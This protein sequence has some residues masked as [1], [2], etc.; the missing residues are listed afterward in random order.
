M[1][2]SA[3]AVI[4]VLYLPRDDRLR[5]IVRTALDFVEE[6]YRDELLSGLKFISF[7]LDS[8]FEVEN[9]KF[10]ASRES[11]WD[12]VNPVRGKLE[13]KPPFFFIS[14]YHP[15][16][17]YVWIPVSKHRR[18]S[19]I[20]T[21][22]A[23]ELA[24]HV[25]YLLPSEDVEG[26]FWA[27]INDLELY[28]LAWRYKASR[29]LATEIHIAIDEMIAIY[30]VHNYFRNLERAPTTP[31]TLTYIHDYAIAKYVET[32]RHP[33]K[34][35]HEADIL[36]KFYFKAAYKDLARF[37][38]ELHEMFIKISKKLPADVLESSRAKYGI[39]YREEPIA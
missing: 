23:H 17:K 8:D 2:G 25:K 11:F 38:K 34:S 29:R 12:V 35:K 30:I 5:M 33:P 19:D 4:N 13:P 14:H 39:L 3:M 37:K 21:S 32:T 31:T 22:I 24:H 18:V 20:F 7:D 27:L 1:R 10:I 16:K 15:I 9:T 6:V 28:D 36:A 26:L